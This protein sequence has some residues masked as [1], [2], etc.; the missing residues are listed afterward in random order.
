MIPT[1][2]NLP[3]AYRG[4]TFD[5]IEF[6]FTDEAGQPILL[7]GVSAAAQVR[8]FGKNNLLFQWIT[9]DGTIQISGNSLTFSAVS[10]DAMRIPAGTHNYDLQINTSGIYDTFING[11]WTIIQ[12]IT[13]VN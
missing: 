7:D 12:D 6:V 5:A 8:G 1:T 9:D 11:T 13:E 10:G 3:D 2:Y 4:D